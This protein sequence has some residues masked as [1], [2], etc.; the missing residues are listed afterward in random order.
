MKIKQQDLVSRPDT[1]FGSLQPSVR[2]NVTIATSQYNRITVKIFS[3][4]ENTQDFHKLE[5]W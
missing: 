3:A 4:L 5:S 1:C 2:N